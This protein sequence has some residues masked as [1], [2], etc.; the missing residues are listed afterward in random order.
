MHLTD[1]ITVPAAPMLGCVGVAPSG[2]AASTVMPSYPTG[3]KHGPTDAR[4]GSMVY[5]PVQVP[6]ALLSVGDIHAAMARG[7]SS[8]V[9]IEAQVTGW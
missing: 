7:E 8:F 3:G 1:R 2:P 9:A 4:P 5:L 6:G